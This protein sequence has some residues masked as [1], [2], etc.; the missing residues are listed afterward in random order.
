MDHV[1]V[2]REPVELRWIRR[3]Y[4]IHRP[5]QNF[6]SARLLPSP[7][8]AAPVNSHSPLLSVGGVVSLA[9]AVLHTGPSTLLPTWVE[10][11]FSFVIPQQG[12]ASR[13]QSVSSP[14]LSYAVASLMNRGCSRF[15][16][17]LSFVYEKKNP[18]LRMKHGPY[19]RADN[20]YPIIQQRTPAPMYRFLDDYQDSQHMLVVCSQGIFEWLNHPADDLCIYLF[21]PTNCR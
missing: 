17:I 2:R 8:H 11:M 13:S 21:L 7:T 12:R 14:V 1:S 16:N 15:L 20:V 10:W 18:S 3:R 6:L 4:F 19:L 5:R 9:D